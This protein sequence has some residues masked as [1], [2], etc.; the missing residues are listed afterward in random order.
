MHSRL[1][2]APL[3]FDLST[4]R[5]ITHHGSFS[6]YEALAREE[7]AQADLRWNKQVWEGDLS[8]LHRLSLAEVIHLQESIKLVSVF[9]VLQLIGFVLH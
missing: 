5:W 2:I 3:N 4:V 6:D 9:D 1:L 7:F 8:D